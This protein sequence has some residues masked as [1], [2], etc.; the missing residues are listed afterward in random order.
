M[1][2]SGIFSSPTQRK[3]F[4]LATVTV[5]ASCLSFTFYI[6]TSA[7]ITPAWSWLNNILISIVASAAFAIISAWYLSYFFVDPTENDAAVTLLPQDIE[8]SLVKIATSA[9]EY[10]IF[11]RTG[12]HFRSEILPILVKQ[13]KKLRR[14]I[15]LEVILLDCRD[16]KICEEYASFRASSSS[17]S[18]TWNKTFVQKEI[19]ATILVILETLQT[20]R[21]F[22]HIE[23]FL[24]K[25]LS[26]FRIEGSADEILVTREDPKDFAHRYVRTHRDFGGYLAEFG[27]IRKEASSIE[28]NNV[29][30]VATVQDIFNGHSDVLQLENSARKIM[31]APSPYA[32]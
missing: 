28:L 5:I 23:L 3:R 6:A 30:K 32:R 12:R 7:T 26:V 27:W 11:V 24:S 25:R 15:R 21:S 10:K 19:L 8:Q 16:G 29:A 2:L 22:V 4:L 14:P 13:A 31:T 17:S 20:S 9:T 1:N 18:K